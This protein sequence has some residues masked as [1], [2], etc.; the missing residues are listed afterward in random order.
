MPN[1]AR[2]TVIWP[3][4]LTAKLYRLPDPATTII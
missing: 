1:V 3:K 4:P 2:M